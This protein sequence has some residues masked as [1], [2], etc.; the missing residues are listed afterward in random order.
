MPFGVT[1]AGF[2]RKTFEDIQAAVFTFLRNGISAVLDLSE[3]DPIGNVVTVVDDEISALWEHAEAAYNSYDVDNADDDRFRALCLLTGVV[4][5]GSTKGTVV[6]QVDLDA[7]QSFPAGTMIAN[8]DGE[9]SNLW[10]NTET[11]TSTSAGVYDADFIATVAG[12]VGVAPAGSLSV[13]TTT[14]AGWNSIINGNDALAGVDIE[15]LEDLRARRDASIAVTGTGTV[16]AIKADVA[17]LNGVISVNVAENTGDDI[18]ENSLPPHSFSVTVWDGPLLD[19]DDDAIAQTIFDSKPAGISAVGG[20]T[21]TATDSDG[22]DHT[23]QYSRAAQVLIEAVATIDTDRAIDEAD[24][25]LA[26]V[27]S[28]NDET[29]V[30]VNY[31]KLA[32][33]V[34]TVVGVTDF[35]NV[36]VN[37]VGDPVGSV[38]IPISINEVGLLD[39]SRITIVINPA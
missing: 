23:I 19:A 5:G 14:L 13:I 34:L 12:V 39:T 2:T 24:V 1:T 26:M 33:S 22:V 7:S 17:A 21:G 32:C 25:K 20:S 6:A 31:N 18:D 30:D 11:V 29:S 16:P 8:V 36:T 10:T 4:P 38:N 9:P 27:A 37:V 15:S 35:T 28:H 3:R